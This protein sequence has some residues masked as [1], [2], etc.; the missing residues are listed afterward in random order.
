[1]F[2][3]V[4]AGRPASG[5]IGAIERDAPPVLSPASL[6]AFGLGVAGVAALLGLAI[7]VVL[8]TV[9]ATHAERIF[10]AV[11]V[12]DVPVGGMPI[13]QAAV[14]LADRAEAIES[15][16]ITFTMRINHG[17]RRCATSACRSTRTRRSRAR[18]RMAERTRR[19]AG[20]GPWPRWRGLASNWRCRSRST[21]SNSIAGSTRSTAVWV[22]RRETP[23]WRSRD[24]RR[25]RAGGRW[26]CRGSRSGS[27][28]G[29]IAALESDADRGR[30]A[31][32]DQDRHHSRGRSGTGA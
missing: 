26:R 1:M 17:P 13:H 10:P 27:S 25:H 32:L 12:A 18:S 14:A 24:Q 16:P 31:G 2:R 3:P 7:A 23:R 8:L 15:S 30:A 29:R 20:C 11:T 19:S 21:I 6:R 4:M 5:W 28:R 22:L 9:R